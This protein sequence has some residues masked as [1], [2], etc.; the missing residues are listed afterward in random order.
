MKFVTKFNNSHTILGTDKERILT[1]VASLNTSFNSKLPSGHARGSPRPWVHGL[2]NGRRFFHFSWFQRIARCNELQLRTT[3]HKANKPRSPQPG[4][5]GIHATS[6][7]KKLPL[8][9]TGCCP[10]RDS[11]TLAALVSLSPDSPTQM[12]RQSFWIRMDRITL[13]VFFSTWE[14]HIVTNIYFSRS[15]QVQHASSSSRHD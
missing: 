9:K 1:N 3:S 4:S 10:V 14:A 12:F 6:N 13:F 15:K 2:C 11:K 7:P 8:E 5:Y